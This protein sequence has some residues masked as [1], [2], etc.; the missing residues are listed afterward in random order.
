M[1]LLPKYNFVDIFVD[2]NIPEWA[3]NEIKEQV[4]KNVKW[5]TVRASISKKLGWKVSAEMMYDIIND[6]DPSSKI[7]SCGKRKRF[8]NFRRGYVFCGS[9]ADCPC[10]VEEAKITRAETNLELH[11]AENFFLTSDFQDKSKATCLE[12]YGTEYY[13]Q[14]DD[15][16]E[17]SK[18]TIM[19]KYGVERIGSSKEIRD[20]IASTMKERYGVVAAMKSPVLRKRFEQIM[21]KRYGVITPMDSKVIRDKAIKSRID[22][23]GVEYPLSSPEIRQ[24]IKDNN[25]TKYGVEFHT[26]RHIKPEHFAILNDP[27]ALRREMERHSRESLA[28]LLCVNVSTIDNYCNKH[29]IYNYRS[30][31]EVEIAAWLEDIGIEYI[32]NRKHSVAQVSLDF[33]LPDY[34]IALEFNGI[35]WHSTA[36]KPDNLYHRKK[37][38]A[39][40]GADIRLLMINEDEW[41][42]RKDAVKSF[43]INILGKSERGSAARKL[44]IAPIPNS[45]AN[46]FYDD[47]HIQGSAGSISYSIAGFE[48]DNLVSAMS[49]T[50]QR[51]TGKIELIRFCSDGKQHQG[52][53]S[54][55]LK[56]AIRE[57]GYQEIISFADLRYSQGNVYLKNGFTLEKEI[58]PDY[59]YVYGDRTYHKSS[60]TKKRIATKFG[61]DMTD[62][63]ERQATEMLGIPRIYDCG[64]L[65]FVWKT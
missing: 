65:K 63:T 53:F 29:G 13:F 42:F 10:S 8:V 6:I 35:Y 15:Y 48:G 52:A 9:F 62:L 61:I 14:S 3:I 32:A 25:L 21:M 19:E 7:T 59:R 12:K 18:E 28:K 26:Q 23:L 60:F 31:Y 22:S 46:S 33:F 2:M 41:L 47:N 30:S 45:I 49:F 20:K 24:K 36:I 27:E 64:K 50:S 4:S 39:C 55:L 17:K 16:L 38:E 56:N 58:S 51:R 57:Q 37:H 34:N 44:R 5:I 1:Y 40:K 54:R 43:I 11:G